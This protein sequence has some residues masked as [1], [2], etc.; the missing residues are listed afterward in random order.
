MANDPNGVI[1]GRSYF[2]DIH[3]GSTQPSITVLSPNGGE[4]FTT[5][6]VYNILWNSLNIP[7]SDYVKI[8]LSYYQNDPTYPGG[9]YIEEWIVEKA[10]NTGTYSWKVPEVYGLGLRES[11]FA[12]KVSSGSVSD[13]SDKK[14]T[15]KMGSSNPTLIVSSPVAGSVYSAGEVVPIRWSPNINQSV[16][17]SLLKKGDTSF[18]R[19]LNVSA[20]GSP[21]E[22]K[23]VIPSGF[24]GNDYYIRVETHNNAIVSGV[25]YSGIFTI[26]S[27]TVTASPVPLPDLAVKSIVITP[28][29]VTDGS[30]SISVA[31]T[32]VNKG[33]KETGP[34]DVSFY[35]TTGTLLGNSFGMASL[36]PGQEYTDTRGWKRPVWTSVGTYGIEV[37]LD[38]ANKI[39]ESDETNNGSSTRFSVGGV[40][41]ATTLY[42]PSL[43]ASNSALVPPQNITL[44]NAPNQTLGGFNVT[45]GGEPVTIKNMVF[46]VAPNPMN[47][48]PVTNITL[49][50]ERGAVVAG[51]V[52]ATATSDSG[53]AYLTVQKFTFTDSVT[54]PV[55]THTYRIVGKLPSTFAN[56]STLSLAT[57]PSLGWTNAVGQITGKPVDVSGVARFYM[58]TMT[59]VTAPT[60]A[61]L[62]AS[63][64]ASVLQSIK[65]TLEQIRA[66][67]AR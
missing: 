18:L 41:E 11:D 49:V 32:F 62:Q 37:K 56:N 61:T 9:A 35:D 22:W 28:S 1:T 15:I 59:V 33:T 51:P 57:T 46:I 60:V 13:Y 53:T 31:T 42:P 50:D 36:A 12:I 45:V 23:G 48:S 25:G 26:T 44:L 54:F 63:Q 40:I 14:F 47:T 38:P 39:T 6:N 10:P 4:S 34:Y 19:W 21:A 52:D 67:L 20:S 64:M 7:S 27:P 24:N 58:S 16:R 3:S 66:S 17:F 2:F 43:S 8:E 30:G 5:G 55:G 29:A 65:E